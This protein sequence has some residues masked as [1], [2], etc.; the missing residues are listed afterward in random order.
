M[1]FWAD[2]D[3]QTVTDILPLKLELNQVSFYLFPQQLILF[4]PQQAILSFIERFCIGF[5]FYCLCIRFRLCYLAKCIH[6]FY[7]AQRKFTSI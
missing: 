7:T 2:G 1:C 3:S 6:M 5:L 4:S